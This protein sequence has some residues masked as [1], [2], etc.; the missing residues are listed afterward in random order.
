MRI[1]NTLT[2]RAFARKFSSV[3]AAEPHSNV[4]AKID[5]IRG[6]VDNFL[7]NVNGYEETNL[8][9]AMPYSMTT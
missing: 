1:T 2:K 8:D 6:Q 7:Q 3:P 5:P 4:R 9:V